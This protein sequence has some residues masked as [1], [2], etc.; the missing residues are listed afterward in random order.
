M[1]APALFDE[2]DAEPSDKSP[3]ADAEASQ[4]PD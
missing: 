2:P 4:S 1:A 3:A